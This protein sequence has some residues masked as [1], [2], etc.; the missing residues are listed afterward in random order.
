LQVSDVMMNRKVADKKQALTVLEPDTPLANERGRIGWFHHNIKS[1]GPQL[2]AEVQGLTGFKQPDPLLHRTF[3]AVITAVKG[4]RLDDLR[5]RSPR[6]TLHRFSVFVLTRHPSTPERW[7]ADMDDTIR[8]VE[9]QD[10]GARRAAHEAWWGEFWNR[11]WIR[12]S[13]DPNAKSSTASIV[14]S[15]AHAVRIGMDQSGG[16]KFAGE[17]GRVSLFAKP[18]PDADIAALARLGREQP[19]AQRQGEAPGPQ[20]LFTGS[21]F[22]PQILTNSAS[23]PLASGFTVEAWVKPSKLSAA[24][25]ASS[26]RS[27]PAAAMAFSSTLTPAIASASSAARPSSRRKTPCLPTNGHTLLPWPTRPQ[28]AAAST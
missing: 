9:A 27:R 17:L 23:W 4:E 16:N 12:A 7:L 3:G 18:L 24:A 6:G 10:F 8:R 22:K 26:T 11:S 21:T 15:N 20:P 5:L 13:T 25:R 19:A 28:A 2:L 14:P 1:V